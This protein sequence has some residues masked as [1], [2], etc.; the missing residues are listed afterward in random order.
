MLGVGCGCIVAIIALV[1]IGIVFAL[2]MG[3]DDTNSEQRTTAT[4]S[5]PQREPPSN[6]AP[7]E[8]APPATPSP[9]PEPTPTPAPEPTPSP[10]PSPNP[11]PHSG[12]IDIGRGVTFDPAEGWTQKETD[13]GKPVQFIYEENGSRIVMTTGDAEE[14]MEAPNVCKI[15]NTALMDKQRKALLEE[16]PAG[17]V[18][19]DEYDA[20]ACGITRRVNPE[21]DGD[22]FKGAK[23]VDVVITVGMNPNADPKKPEFIV[24]LVEY[25]VGSP[26]GVE[27]ERSAV[28]T[29]KAMFDHAY[30]TWGVPH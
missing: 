27:S 15:E 3:D 8:S 25:P 18:R 29:G 20:V 10:E 6:T 21:T 23:S 17:A 16:I 13:P 9:A 2:L 1:V 12:S 7:S 14:G 28:K 24:Q 11:E 30:E 4:A 5:A 22:R 26:A 19:F